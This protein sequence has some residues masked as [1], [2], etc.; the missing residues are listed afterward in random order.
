MFGYLISFHYYRRTDLDELAEAAGAP[1]L[2]FLADSGAFS[3]YTQGAQVR[4]EDYAAWLERWAH[5]VHAYA[6]LDVLFDPEA[7]MAN[8]A[9]LRELG[10]KDA[11]PVFHLGS[12]MEV[13]ERYVAEE[14]Y[15]GVGGMAS[16][17]LTMK[18]A[19][20]WKYLD[21]LHGKAAAAGT[22]LHGF[23]LS[24]WPVVKRFPWYSFDSSTAGSG[25]R[26]G[27]VLVFDPYA[28]RWRG[29]GLR[30]RR[31]WHRHGWLVREYGMA[32][33]DFVGTNV[34]V[35]TPLITIAARSWSRATAT[36]AQRA[37]VVDTSTGDKSGPHWMGPWEAGNR[38]RGYLTDAAF[39]QTEGDRN[40]L[41]AYER[42]NR[43]APSS[44]NETSGPGGPPGA[45]AG[46][47][48]ALPL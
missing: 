1:E 37:Y 39:M 24:S 42:G 25:Y 26:Y 10:A 40:R 13:F 20:L 15:V 27:R 2:T 32:P 41:G 35:R 38:W 19:R 21:V 34:Q 8:T 31:A 14:P 29:W 33:A 47:T 9:R 36:L 3:A 23:G 16:G 4:L 28:D 6:S 22:R 30:D 45:L 12:P 46:A 44:Q 5:R 11:M 48:P 43:W 17:T 7:T 18:D